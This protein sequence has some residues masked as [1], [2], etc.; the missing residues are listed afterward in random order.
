MLT[1]NLL[2]TRT[3]SLLYTF[4]LVY[5]RHK[6]FV[7]T[8]AFPL[9]INFALKIRIKNF[10]MMQTIERWKDFLFIVTL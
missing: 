4:A 10:R 1:H 3:R 7:S 6:F 2:S 9:L 8:H 5:G